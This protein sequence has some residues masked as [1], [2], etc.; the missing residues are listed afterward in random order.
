MGIAGSHGIVVFVVVLA[1]D[2]PRDSRVISAPP[3]SSD[4]TS[5]L[6]MKPDAPLMRTRI[7]PELDVAVGIGLTLSDRKARE[8][9]V[10]NYEWK[11]FLD[12][13]IQCG[14]FECIDSTVF[15][16]SAAARGS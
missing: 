6:P 16:R 10:R 9:V 8:H 14:P 15:E 4:G 12:A 7:A 13:K 5:A 3:D 11:E 2:S 1:P